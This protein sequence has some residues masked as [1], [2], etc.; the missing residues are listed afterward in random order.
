MPALFTQH[1]MSMWLTADD[2]RIEK[3]ARQGWLIIISTQSSWALARC[4]APGSA[5]FFFS[6]TPCVAWT[7]RGLLSKFYQRAAAYA[8][9]RMSSRSSD[10]D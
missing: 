1:S 7:G 3:Q 9:T 5:D 10:L 2:C 8:R 4:S 6:P